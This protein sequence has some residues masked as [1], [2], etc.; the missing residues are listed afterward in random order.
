ME[1]GRA[2]GVEVAPER[3]EAVGRAT[4][5]R[6]REREEAGEMGTSIR[7]TLE[8]TRRLLGMCH[9]EKGRDPRLIIDELLERDARFRRH[10]LT[11]DKCR[12]VSEFLEQDWANG[13]NSQQL[14]SYLA[15]HASTVEELEGEVESL[16][17]RRAEL[18]ERL[19]ELQA[20]CEEAEKRLNDLNVSYGKRELD[21]R[22]CYGLL[23]VKLKR[24]RE[25]LEKAVAEQMED[26]IELART[27]KALQQVVSEKRITS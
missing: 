15:S 16:K 6:R 17:A 23:N 27:Y 19:Q 22:G 11:L 3:V 13:W 5:A 8:Q 7:L 20:A 21:L 2:A 25:E 14:A 26:L 4:E 12:V 9:L 1:L 24:D 10:G 18:E